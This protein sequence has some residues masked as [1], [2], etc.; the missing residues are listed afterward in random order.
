LAPA[1]PAL[2]APADVPPLVGDVDGAVVV[3]SSTGGPPALDAL[4]APLPA[5]FPWP[6]LVAQHMPANFT[7]P[8]A[9]RLDRLCDLTVLEVAQPVPLAPGHVYI[10]RGDA[11]L[12]VGRRPVGLMALPA[13]SQ[14]GYRWHPSADRLVTSAMEHV[15]P[16]RLVGILMTGMGN[17]GAA[18]MTALRHAGGRTIAEA[19]ATAIVWGMPGE[20]VR[21][22]GAE[23]VVPLG[24]IAARL[25]DLVP[26]R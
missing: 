20:L 13:P 12:I 7:G 17:D 14:A 1:R 4:L 6:I 23:F 2:A 18:A 25:L 16:K 3:G 9:R 10:A 24:G 15:G 5:S 19:E 22:G 21:A 11:D 26:V 8:L